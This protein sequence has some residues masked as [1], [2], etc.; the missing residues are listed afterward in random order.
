MEILTKH[1]QG[2]TDKKKYLFFSQLYSL[3]HAGLSF[4][5]SFNLL[6]DGQK[7]KKDSDLMKRIYTHIIE[8]S[9]FW[10]SMQMTVA[11]TALDCGVIRIGEET[12]KLEQSLLFL[13]DYYQKK[14]EQR[15]M[16]IGALSYPLII[17]IVALLV[18]SF[19]ITVVIPMFE[20]IYT[21]MGGN[22]PGITQL[23]LKLSANFPVVLTV[24]GLLTLI[25]IGTKL[26]YGEREEYRRFTTGLLLRIPLIGQL[27]RIHHQA[28]FCKLLYLLVSSEVS[29]LSSL[30]M[31]T[32]IIRFY[33]YSRSF[34]TIAQ[35]L[36]RGETFSD[37][38]ARFEDLYGNKLITL[39]R[40]GEETNSLDQMLLNQSKDI[41]DELEH[42]LKQ[43][44]NILEPVLILVIG[45]IVA[46]I[47]IAMYM[48]MFQLEQNFN[49]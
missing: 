33:P 38:M 45:A 9:E 42:E 7:K 11:F 26:I 14:N 27:I 18:L 37:N 35:G 44:G 32:S 46:F 15:R 23:M 2:I 3:L 4:S 31:L 10:Q 6:I 34:E 28:Q 19:M 43:L 20:Q 21:R 8:G 48:P 5:R 13:S 30:T 29:L 1:S 49:G 47:L 22:L 24:L 41:T 36:R 12:G 39:I 40:V 17:I 16:L 25:L